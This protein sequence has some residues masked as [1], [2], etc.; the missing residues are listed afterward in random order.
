[1]NI[2][3]VNDLP[4]ALEA[5]RRAVA[6]LPGAVVV[7]TAMNGEEAI[8]ACHRVRPDLILMDM[9]MPV[10][11][12]VE[13]TRRIMKECPCPILVV[14]ATVTGNAT[15]VYEA[16]GAGAVDAIE[17]PTL[18]STEGAERL[19]RRI[20]AIGRY[21]RQVDATTH[22]GLPTRTKG[23]ATTASRLVLIGSSTGG[24]QALATILKSWARPI[25]FAAVVVQ[26]LDPTFVPG[27]AEW[28]SRD[29]AHNVQVA[30]AG[31]VPA[32][33]TIWMAMGPKHLVFDS[34]GR[35]C[36]REPDP[37]DLHVPS[38]NAL[39]QSAAESGLSPGAA[40]L[41]TGMGSDGATGLLQLKTAGW[42]TIAQDQA[43]SVVWGMPGAATRLH[44][45]TRTL[46]LHSIGATLYTACTM[47]P[48]TP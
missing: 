33:G 19:C 14:T 7:W 2:A 15:R 36:N 31:M 25:P 47:K 4:L 21:S 32:P 42:T 6:M 38:V 9:I 41:L 3:L 16:L 40:A 8:H 12:G 48:R 37:H 46:P 27:L 34:A 43:S 11:D 30:K 45:A 13:A 29:S 1:M 26:H 20:E 18:T 24:P 17:T 35:L 28:L 44:A 23:V 5:L 10:M 39:F 22:I